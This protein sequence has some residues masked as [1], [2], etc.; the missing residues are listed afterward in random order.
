MYKEIV[1]EGKSFNTLLDTG[2]PL[3]LM[4]ED[5]FRIINAARLG[6]G[7]IFDWHC[8]RSS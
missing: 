7:S 4:H 8:S 5:V 2:S 3:S 6:I 1:I